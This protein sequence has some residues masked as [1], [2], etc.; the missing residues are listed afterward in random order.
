MFGF[1][2][3]WKTTQKSSDIWIRDVLKH[4]FSKSLV[5][6]KISI[7]VFSE[8]LET[9]SMKSSSKTRKTENV[10]TSSDMCISGLFYCF[11]IFTTCF[12]DYVFWIL[13]YFSIFNY[14]MYLGLQGLLDIKGFAHWR[15]S[16]FNKFRQES[17]KIRNSV[18]WVVLTCSNLFQNFSELVLPPQVP[19]LVL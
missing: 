12:R 4:V 13:W 19:E 10:Q 11:R 16:S 8:N 1:N 17:E 5:H 18:F 3:Y 14:G 9:D 2:N 7:H 15:S 6:L